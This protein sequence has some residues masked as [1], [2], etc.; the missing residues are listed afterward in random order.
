[1]IRFIYGAHGSGKTEYIT[2]RIAEDCAAGRRAFLIVP[3]QE[4]VLAERRAA[5]RLP[6]SSALCFEVLNFTRLCNRVFREYGGLSAKYASEGMRLVTMMR[7]LRACAPLLSVYRNAAM[8][9]PSFAAGMLSAV[10]ELAACGITPG[11]IDAA[12]SSLPDASLSARLSDISACASAYRE[13]LGGG[14][15]PSGR[16]ERLIEVLK[17]ERFFAGANVYIDSFSGLTGIQHEAVAEIMSQAAS[18]TVAVPLESPDSDPGIDG[19]S[20]KRMSSRLR[21][22]AAATGIRTETVLTGEQKRTRYADLAAAGRLWT[23]FPEEGARDGSVTVAA[24]SDIFEEAEYA[25]AE[26][27]KLLR[28]GMRCRDI[29]ICVRDPDRYRGILDTAFEDAGIPFWSSGKHPL[30]HTAPA[31]LLLS[32]LKIL[33]GGWRREDVSA[34]LHTGLSGISDSDLGIFD[35]Y[36]EK[37]NI[38]GSAFTRGDWQMHPDGYS[39]DMSP[40]DEDRLSRINGVRKSVC[41]MLLKLSEELSAAG[42]CGEICLSL[43][44]FLGSLGVAGNMRSRAASALEAGRRDEAVKL[45]GFT[46]GLVSCLEE[47]CDCYGGAPAPALSEFTSALS[48]M[49]DAKRVG[50]IP[51]TADAVTLAPADVFRADGPRCVMLLGVAEG[52]FPAAPPSRGLFSDPD[53]ELMSECGLPLS[54][55]PESDASDEL[56][57]FSRA[58]ASAS[59]KLI[60]VT[61]A[62]AISTA[63]D[64]LLSVLPGLRV[65]GCFADDFT[66]R[67]TSE[68]TAM[69][70]LPLL[71]GTP[72]GSA[73]AAALS[74]ASRMTVR[75]RDSSLEDISPSTAAAVFGKQMYLSESALAEYYDCPFKFACGRLLKLDRVCG[76]RAYFSF[77]SVG[78]YMHSVLEHYLREIYLSRGGVFPEGDEKAALLSAISESVKNGI[79]PGGSGSLSASVKHMTGRLDALSDAVTSRMADELSASDFVPRF[80]ELKIGGG[81]FPATVFDLPD[82]G[83]ASLIGKA[84]RVDVMEKDGKAY[85]RVVDYKTGRK[86]PSGSAYTDPKTMQLPLYLLSLSASP[87]VSENFFGMPAVPSSFYYLFCLPEKPES[88]TSDA[89][90]AERLVAGK[91]KRLGRYIDGGAGAGTD[92][93]EDG[94]TP[95]KGKAAGTAAEFSAATEEELRGIFSGA[96]ENLTAAA[97]SMR[98]GMTAARPASPDSCKNCPFAAVC[99]RSGSPEGGESAAGTDPMTDSGAGTAPGSV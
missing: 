18:T 38:N 49:L 8:N 25:A 71:T 21:R 1:M 24:A 57:Y 62:G 86:F 65:S 99:R 88:A 90:E 31:R 42:S 85:V 23:A 12:A 10:D 56:Y 73:V 9:D 29:V 2:E 5:E 44:R 60:V 13:L 50:S 32:V 63:V 41:D 39:G 78:N 7:A 69:G 68:R 51:A 67:F 55:D 46:D 36:T 40:E 82:G 43:Y 81:G 48:L 92:S 64:R 66:D 59:E 15:D 28:A 47:L 53:R 34:F 52:S 3:E 93:P 20:R 87:R 76:Q 4:G 98:K 14:A 91:I 22:D 61:R 94:G 11:G 79:A 19:I 80:F 74:G 95:K 6:A 45:A 83:R 77:D 75:D 84:D 30:S 58:A 33:T 16:M 27:G 96:A 35:S 17:S 72:L 89:G 37:W 70:Y 26:A 54:S 97:V